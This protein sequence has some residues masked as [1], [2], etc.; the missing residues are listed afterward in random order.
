MSAKAESTPD[1][2]LR[3]DIRRVTSIL[4]ETLAR[5]EGQ[6]LLDL[7][8][9]VRKHAKDRSLDQLPDFDLDTITTLVRAFTAYFHLANIT[10]QVHRGRALTRLAE[11]E[12][13]W[14]ERAVARIGEAGIDRDEL[15]A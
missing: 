3:R 7:V 9:R 13:G 4:G 15:A 1:K 8:E 12:G 6:E 10:E 14:I 11:E 5:A 2:A